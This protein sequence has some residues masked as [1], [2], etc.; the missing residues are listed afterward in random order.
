MKVFMLLLLVFFPWICQAKNVLSI[1]YEIEGLAPYISVGND[2]NKPSGIIIDMLYTAA[3]TLDIE[4]QFHR[5]P[6]LRCQ[7]MVQQNS[8][9]ATLGMIWTAQRAQQFRFP[10][11]DSGT[12]HSA[13]YLWLAQYPVFSSPS[14]PFN[15][16]Q[17]QPQFG[18]SAPLGYVVEEL[19]QNKGWLSPYQVAAENGLQLV[20]DGKLDGYSVE[21]QVGLHHLQRL[22]L[23]DKITVSSENLL[24]E[25]WF[26]VF[27]M[28]FYQKNH[29]LAE[30]LWF[31]LAP[32]RQALEVNY[33]EQSK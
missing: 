3:S 15:L 1:C 19:L 30:Q 8:L 33:P 28:D 7:K 27:N 6:W 16:Q 31:N 5:A 23:T 18:I 12:A 22:Q 20:I 24:T 10:D 4:L 29:T 25:K 11:H 9:N 13:R 26:L 14:T 32:V 2:D 17:Y 21:R